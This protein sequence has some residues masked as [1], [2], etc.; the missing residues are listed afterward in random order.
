MA[1][2][3]SNNKSKGDNITVIKQHIT[4][5]QLRRSKIAIDDWRQALNAAE[6]V[7]NPLRKRLYEIY[8]ELMLDAHLFAIID[9]RIRQITN[10][11]IVWVDANGEPN[12]EITKLF[13]KTW[14]NDLVF[15][16]VNTIF[17]GHTLIEFEMKE[18]D[19]CKT[20]VVPRHHVRPELGIVGLSS[21]YDSQGIAYRED[22]YFSYTLEIQTKSL[23]LLNIAAA[24]AIFKR[25]G[26]VD[27]SNLVEMFGMP[28]RHYEYDPNI[29]NAKQ[30]TETAAKEFGS[31]A[32]IIT[33]KDYA[34]LTLHNG[35]ASGNTDIHTD[36]LKELKD[37][38]SILI[39]GQTMT[40][41]D[42]SSRSQAEVHKGEQ[43][44]IKHDDKKFVLF[45][46]NEDFLPK[47]ENLGYPVAG[48]QFTF[49]EKETIP[50]P[51]QLEMDLL[52][53]AK[54]KVPASY[55]AEKYNIPIDEGETEAPTPDAP[56]E[57]APDDDLETKAA[58]EIYD[59][60]NQNPTKITFKRFLNNLKTAFNTGLKKKSIYLYKKQIIEGDF[61]THEELY[62]AYLNTF[63]AEVHKHI[64]PNTID[65][66]K[67]EGLRYIKLRQ[68][69]ME[70]ASAK[71][72][73]LLKDIKD[74]KEKDLPLNKVWDKHSRW[75]DTEKQ[76]FSATAQQVTNW[77]AIEKDQELFP[78]LEYV[79]VEDDHTR[80]E[81]KKLD[82]IILPINHPFWNTYHPKNGYK[83][84][85]IT[86]RKDKYFDPTPDN[87][88]PEIK[89][90]PVFQQNS[91]KT[92]MAFTK[93][94]SYFTDIDKQFTKKQMEA[95]AKATISEAIG[96]EINGVKFT[97]EGISNAIN[98]AINSITTKQ[99]L[100]LTAITLTEH[101]IKNA[102]IVF[103]DGDKTY[104]DAG[105]N[106]FILLI[107]GVF[108]A[109]LETLDTL[110][111]GIKG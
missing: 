87:K 56:K 89:I 45:R 79:A 68:N 2:R 1:L 40:T 49:D 103:E 55:F 43:E 67:P 99:P 98:N 38:L 80:P 29:P 51:T 84:R 19:I 18:G 6:S 97:K 100:K 73:A 72:T 10:I 90:H 105:N 31:A 104:L 25:Y 95:I 93:E 69:A 83:C 61:D 111:K 88:L 102:K 7:Y 11:P 33:P 12:E 37:E 52:I 82:G 48:G 59:Y 63:L 41:K 20:E 101:L 53:A 22:P 76:Q 54:Y 46:L 32:S 30:E 109:I 81:H 16:I 64:D 26:V 71:M 50:I 15:E 106:I 66:S 108:S 44:A 94:H 74:A 86:I 92:G 78:Y 75:L 4:V 17:W 60:L 62:G 47:L 35:V 5:Q 39:L 57:D 42:G 9:K 65:F 24:N 34:N 70:F 28:I 77:T 14:F 27:F 8:N 96:K 21:A 85:C 23:G 3:G 36:F 13:E 58:K 91:G 107:K 110:V